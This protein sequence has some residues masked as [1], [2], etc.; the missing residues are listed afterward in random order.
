[1]HILGLAAAIFII[2][3]Y[4]SCDEDDRPPFIGILIFAAIT[5]V[6]FPL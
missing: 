6:L 1:M 5:F 2:A 4:L 3:S